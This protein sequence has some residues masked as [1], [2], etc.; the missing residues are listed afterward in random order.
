MKHKNKLK[1]LESRKNHFEN[2]R[3][4]QDAIKTNPGSYHK[5]GSVKK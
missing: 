4:I 5:P 1:K 3:Y 2:D